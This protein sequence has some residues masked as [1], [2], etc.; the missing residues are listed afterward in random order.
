MAERDERAA[1]LIAKLLA[2]VRARFAPPRTL[3]VFT[4]EVLGFQG[5]VVSVVDQTTGTTW[6][7]RAV[8]VVNEN[9]KTTSES[10]I[11]FLFDAGSSPALSPGS[12]VRFKSRRFVV[13]DLGDIRGVTVREIN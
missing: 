8:R 7:G 12:V 2:R 5:S 3:V 4:M 9:P 13:R 10:M 1:P 6:N 11:G